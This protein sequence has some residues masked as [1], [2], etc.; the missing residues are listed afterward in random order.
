MNLL[1]GSTGF[2]GTHI[3]NDLSKNEISTLALCRRIIPNLPDNVTQLKVDFSSFPEL[4]ISQID[5]VYLSLGCPLYFHNAMG[6]MNTTLKENLFRVDFNY[7]L[8]IAKKCQEVGAKNVSLIS[9]AGAD[10]NSWNYYLKVKGMLE[11]EIIKLG[12]ERTNI[13]RPGH[14]LGNKFR[15]DIRLADLACFIVNPFLHGSFKKFRSISAKKLSA[16]VVN[17]KE[18]KEAINYFE[19]NDFI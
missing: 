19:F 12:F 6:F 13:F 4:E 9:A 11:Q 18:K 14:L 8:A 3:L 15:L 10:P 1:A 5:H 7:Q 17:H 16:F 2:L